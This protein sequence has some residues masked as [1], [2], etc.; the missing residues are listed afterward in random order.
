MNVNMNEYFSQIAIYTSWH[1]CNDAVD[2]KKVIVGAVLCL[3]EKL[4]SAPQTIL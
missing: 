4:F 2:E 1:C 3:K